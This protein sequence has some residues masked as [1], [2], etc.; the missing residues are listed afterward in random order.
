[1]GNEQLIII[2][3]RTG[4]QIDYTSDP[5]DCQS[6]IGPYTFN[7]IYNGHGTNIYKLVDE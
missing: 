4:A 5:D 3:T 7:S 2:N 6:P 1:M